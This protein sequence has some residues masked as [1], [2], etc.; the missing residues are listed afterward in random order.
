MGQCIFPTPWSLGEGNAHTPTRTRGGG[1]VSAAWLNRQPML[2]LPLTTQAALESNAD[3]FTH[4]T[5]TRYRMDIVMV[6]ANSCSDTLLIRSR[7]VAVARHTGATRGLEQ[8]ADVPAAAAPHR[9]HQGLK[10]TGLN[11]WL[12]VRLRSSQIGSSRVN[13]WSWYFK[14][15]RPSGRVSRAPLGYRRVRPA[16]GGGG[17]CRPL[18]FNI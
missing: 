7:A 2:G 8:T 5:D 13:V 15:K 16:A 17:G 3:N 18:I 1:E 4:M 6:W 10:Q 9:R 14:V 11:M 12:T